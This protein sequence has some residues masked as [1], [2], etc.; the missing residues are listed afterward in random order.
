MTQ[1]ERLKVIAS[2]K[3]FMTCQ[4]CGFTYMP[5]TVRTEKRCPKC[6][7]MS[8]QIKI[9]DP[10]MTYLLTEMRCEEEVNM[11]C[12]YDGNITYAELGL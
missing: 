6:E 10:D 5:M 11:D 8:R 2:S 7:P 9:V 1:T 12:L 3:Y 4:C